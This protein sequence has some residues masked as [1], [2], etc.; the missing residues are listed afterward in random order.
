MLS[1]VSENKELND[2]FKNLFS[3]EGSEIYLKPANA[4]V[5][6]GAAMTFTTVVAAAAMKNESAIGYKLHAHAGDASKS[7]GVV[8]NPEKSLPVTFGPHDR[9]IVLADN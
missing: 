8:V 3:P 6:L 1:Q 2:V 5:K 9:V 4:Y 7:Y